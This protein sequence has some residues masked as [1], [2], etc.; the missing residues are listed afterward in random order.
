MGIE[1]DGA[2][3][4]DARTIRVDY[5]LLEVRVGVHQK[6]F[7]LLKLEGFCILFKF[8]NIEISI[9]QKL[10]ITFRIKDIKERLTIR[11]GDFHYVLL[12]VVHVNIGVVT[13][14]SPRPPFSLIYDPKYFPFAS[15]FTEWPHY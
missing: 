10:C 5:L 6:F 3:T 11:F 9:Y 12:V 1:P 7:S 8:S 2:L 15:Q 14:I 13:A 4:L